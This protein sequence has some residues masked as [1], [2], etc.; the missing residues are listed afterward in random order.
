MKISDQEVQNIID[1]EEKRLQETLDF[2][3]SENYPSAAVKE[4]VGS[5]FIG[6]YAEGYPGARY[7]EGRENIDTL[8]SLAIERAKSLF[9]AEHA[10]V[11]AYSGAIANLAIYNA[12]LRPGDTIMGLEL[13]HG[14]HLSH[15]WKVT[16]SAKVY[17]SVQYQLGEDE[18]LDYDPILELAREVKPAMI[19]SGYSAYSQAIDFK[20]FGEIAAEV[21]ALHLADISHIAGLVAAG[22]HESPVPHADVVMTTTH[23]T[24]RGPRGALILCKKE[25]AKAIDRSVFPGIQGGPHQNTI[26]GIAVA[27]EE[28]S[29]PEFKEYGKQV[30]ANAAVL[31]DELAAKGLRI[32]SGG[33]ENH[34]MLVD[35]TETGIT[36]SEAASRLLAAGM[37][38]NRNTIPF[39]TRSPFDPSGIRIGT[40]AVTTRGMAEAEMKQIATWMHEAI[41]EERPAEEILADVMNLAKQFPLPS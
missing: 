25:H 28:A 19:I 13:T 31:A 26:A 29:T 36:G 10:N 6:E 3:P 7:Y 1:L 16:L 23:K 34:L 20:R 17:N 35:L 41:F 18:R 11:Q 5:V 2:V 37:N 27:L 9:G 33:T 22:A 40:P 32:V 30:V 14:G 12:L 4:A 21:G 38:V 39:E 24:L 15:G 8:E